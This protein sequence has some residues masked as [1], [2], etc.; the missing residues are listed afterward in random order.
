MHVIPRRGPQFLRCVDSP[1]ARTQAEGSEA[2][3]VYQ[4]LLEQSLIPRRLLRDGKPPWTAGR[5]HRI[6]T[7]DTGSIFAGLDLVGSKPKRRRGAEE[8]KAQ[9]W[10][11]DPWPLSS[12]EA[13]LFRTAV[14]DAARIGAPPTRTVLRNS[15]YTACAVRRPHSVSLYCAGPARSINR[16]RS[17]DFTV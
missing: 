13:P 10:Q 16:R 8:A 9:E 11:D 14:R 1:V 4:S 6:M 17:S 3:T 7:A 15:S 2:Q 12:G 5:G